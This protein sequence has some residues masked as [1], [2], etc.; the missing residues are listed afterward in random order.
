MIRID[1][2]HLLAS[3]TYLSGAHKHLVLMRTE[4]IESKR[5]GA[6][7]IQLFSGIRECSR[8]LGVIADT[9]NMPAARASSGRLV[10]NVD[11]VAPFHLGLSPDRLS[12]VVSEISI[13]ISAFQDEM[14]ERLLF[15][16]PPSS[17]RYFSGKPPFG[18]EVE[19]AFPAVSHDIVEAGRCL[20]LS[21]WTA[22]V[23]HLMRVLE[24]GLEALAKRFDVPAGENWNTVLNAIESKLREVRRKVDGREQEQWAAE[25]GV[26][27]RFIKNAWR[28]HAMH[29]LE[30]YDAERAMH[31]FDNTRSFMQHLAK[32]LSEPG[33]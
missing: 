11:I 15:A 25:A 18:D 10:Q 31:I 28:N 23:M 2:H 16:F 14:E 30:R 29:Q 4:A 20:A 7:D 26:H 12:L 17:A 21:R 27:L 13:L 6:I 5:A 8:R 33:R 32:E 22:T 19:E 1:V 24:A 3:L 9:L